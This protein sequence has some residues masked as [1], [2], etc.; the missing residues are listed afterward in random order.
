MKDCEL[1][2]IL[3]NHERT[4]ILDE[5]NDELK[6]EILN[7][8]LE[9]LNELIP[10]VNEGLDNAF[11]EEELILLIQDATGR[12]MDEMEPTL[13]LRT[14][15]GTIIGEEVYDEE[16]LEELHERDDTY[17]LSDNFVTY[18]NLSTPKEE[19]IFIIENIYPDYLTGDNLEK[20]VNSLKIASPSTVTDQHIK[21]CFNL[22]ID[23]D[24]E[25]FIIG[26]TNK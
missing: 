16:E 10:A 7:I 15:S 23:D 4:V 13:T 5:I 14:K 6:K 9:R 2:T 19:Q 18:T 3:K 11:K 1:V 26:F 21:K 25:T 20:T 17:F 8:E 12:T 22:N 24:L